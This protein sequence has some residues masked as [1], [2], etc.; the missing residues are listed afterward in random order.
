MLSA[1]EKGNFKKTYLI[2]FAL[3]LSSHK[4]L[5]FNV[6]DG[7]APDSGTSEFLSQEHW[8]HQ[9]AVRNAGSQVPPPPW[10]HYMRSRL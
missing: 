6:A 4:W 9:G 10:T 5:V 8:P 1:A 7:A 3:R 2:N